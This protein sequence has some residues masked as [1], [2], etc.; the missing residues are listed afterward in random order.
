MNLD[1]LKEPAMFERAFPKWG[2]A[3]WR[4]LMAVGVLVFLGGVAFFGLH[5]FATLRADFGYSA[6]PPVASQATPSGFHSAQECGVQPG[7]GIGI[8]NM[9]LNTTLDNVHVEGMERGIQNCG[10]GAKIQNSDVKA[11]TVPPAAVP[12]P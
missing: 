10:D 4:G 12:K 8:V 2:F 11:Q 7:V 5:G 3:V 9:G 6:V 1:F